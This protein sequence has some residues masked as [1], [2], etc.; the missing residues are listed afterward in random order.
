MIVM[1]SLTDNK[2]WVT[3]RQPQ[4][5]FSCENPLT[6]QGY[7]K[8]YLN[9]SGFVVTDWGAAHSASL[10]QGLDWSAITVTSHEHGPIKLDW[11]M[12]CIYAFIH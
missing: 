7:L 2:V 10:K 1:I 6:L 9:F 4:P 8:E 5:I 3:D 11:S 12:A